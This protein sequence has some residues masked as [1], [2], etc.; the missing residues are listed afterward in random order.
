M[1][2]L[3]DADVADK[4]MQQNNSFIDSAIL[5]AIPTIDAVPVVRCQE[6]KHLNVINNPKLYAHCPKTNTVF[7]PFD[8][9]TR[10]HFC[11]LGERKIETVL[12]KS[13]AKDESLEETHA[14]T[15][16]T[17]AD[18]IENAR[19]QSEEANM[20]KPLKDWTLGEAKEYCTSRNGNCADDCIFSKKGIGMVC[21]IAPK[22]VWWTLPEK[23]SFT[24]QEAEAAKA[25]KVLFPCTT[26]LIQ[27]Q[28]NEPVSAKA[29]DAFVVN[30]NSVLFPS[31]QPG[32]PYTLDEIIGGAE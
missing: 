25:V 20:D 19:V 22:P 9:D 13:D 16:K 27:F 10:E 7:L 21:G 28:P 30:L 8:L 2:R 23:P 29:G 26:H 3:I 32:K 5:K 31:I 18:A 1:P 17:H 6:C 11:S 12:P 14:N 4:W 15:R 24:E